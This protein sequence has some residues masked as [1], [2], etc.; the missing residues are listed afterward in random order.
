M[1]YFFEEEP[2]DWA[3]EQQNAQQQQQQEQQQNAEDGPPEEYQPEPWEI[4][5]VAADAG[6]S[7]RSPAEYDP[8]APNARGGCR[9]CDSFTVDLRWREAFGV[10]LCAATASVACMSVRPSSHVGVQSQRLIGDWC[11]RQ[12]PL[13][14]ARCGAHIEG[15]NSASRPASQA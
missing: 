14:Q 10:Y 3:E 11:G 12:V 13:V 1:A 4:D 9:N 8:L 15:A 5:G 2:D 7:G 6:H